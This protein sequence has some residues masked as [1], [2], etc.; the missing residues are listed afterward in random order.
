[1]INSFISH[2]IAY[3]DWFFGHVFHAFFRFS[4]S[5]SSGDTAVNDIKISPH[6]PKIHETVKISCSFV[7]GL[8][9]EDD[10]D[11]FVSH[12]KDGKNR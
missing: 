8:A 5:F 12:D 4:A 3:M 1:M 10:A 7:L 9:T 6:E 11:I 2:K